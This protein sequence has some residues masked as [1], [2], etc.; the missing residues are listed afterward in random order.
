MK[1]RRPS[2]IIILLG[3]DRNEA[4]VTATRVGRPILTQECIVTS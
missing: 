4:K 1:C 2:G 3:A